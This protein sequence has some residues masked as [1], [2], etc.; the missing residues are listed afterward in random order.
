MTTT[1]ET[2]YTLCV[3][4]LDIVRETEDLKSSKYIKALISFLVF[5]THVKEKQYNP[6]KYSGS[7]TGNGYKDS[8]QLMK[9]DIKKTISAIS[10][11]K[12]K[13]TKELDDIESVTSK[14]MKEAEGNSIQAESTSEMIKED[15]KGL[16][17]CLINLDFDKG[18]NVLRKGDDPIILDDIE[19]KD[20]SH[21]I[22]SDEDDLR[23]NKQKTS[24]D[25]RSTKRAKSGMTSAGRAYK[26]TPQILQ[27]PHADQSQF[28]CM[29][30][31]KALGTTK[32]L[33]MKLSNQ[34]AR[35]LIY[36]N[37][38]TNDKIP[39]NIGPALQEIL[40]QSR[41]K[42]DLSGEP[43]AALRD[44]CSELGIAFN[45]APLDEKFCERLMEPAKSHDEAIH[46]MNTS[47]AL[48]HWI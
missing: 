12:S 48:K 41:L 36:R 28:S 32:T 6:I 27:V 43:K 39:T 5:P 13:P 24:I 2:L 26:K 40:E 34:N 47:K 21:N 23:S 37:K 8:I 16:A 30:L 3:L 14:E 33:F 11:S 18:P 10:D 29:D 46:F 25:H 38:G 35:Y 7:E 45:L 1:E 44:K 31:V 4:V 20:S 9:Q 19:S 42:A 22:E 15:D 17:S